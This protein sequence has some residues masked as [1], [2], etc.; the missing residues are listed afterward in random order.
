LKTV[1]KVPAAPAVPKFWCAPSSPQALIPAKKRRPE[2]DAALYCKKQNEIV[3]SALLAHL[4]EAL[5][6]VDGAVRLRLKGNLRLA[7]AGSANSGE[8]LTGT[9]GGVLAGIA[10]GLA[11][12]RLVLE[13]ALSVEL[14]LTGGEHELLAALFAH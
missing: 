12:L 1:R 5:A 2:R 3:L 7:A 9:A 13:A 10:A 11:A 14:L 6:A 8:V 4:G